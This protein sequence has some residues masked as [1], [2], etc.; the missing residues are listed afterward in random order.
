MCDYPA[1]VR[2]LPTWGHVCSM[3]KHGTCVDLCNLREVDTS[4]CETLRHAKKCRSLSM[5]RHSVLRRMYKANASLMLGA[6]KKKLE[7]GALLLSHYEFFCEVFKDSTSD[8]RDWDRL[9]A[10]AWWL[11]SEACVCNSDTYRAT[12]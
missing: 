7:I 5:V 8:Q 3:P 10:M 9:C 4:K 1:R 6:K 11:L 2:A 12:C